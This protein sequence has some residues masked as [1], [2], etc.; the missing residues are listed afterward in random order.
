MYLSLCGLSLGLRRFFLLV[1]WLFVD[2]LKLLG[3]IVGTPLHLGLMCWNRMLF[4]RFMIRILRLSLCSSLL[5]RLIV[6]FFLSIIGSGEFL[7]VSGLSHDA[8]ALVHEPRV[9]N[10][11][12]VVIAII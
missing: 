8:I 2:F 12:L 10:A 9:A 5:V 6:R 7:L 3:L 11:S 4:F 1:F